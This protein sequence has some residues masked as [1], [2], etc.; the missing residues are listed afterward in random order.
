MLTVPNIPASTNNNN[1]KV[2]LTVSRNNRRRRMAKML[3]PKN[4]KANTAQT[5]AKI[6]NRSGTR[7]PQLTI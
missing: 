6:V 3:A 7:S 5:I 1:P 4:S 2:K